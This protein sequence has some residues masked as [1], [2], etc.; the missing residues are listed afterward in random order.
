MGQGGWS[1]VHIA[2]LEQAKNAQSKLLRAVRSANVPGLGFGTVR[3][4]SGHRFFS[5]LAA[6]QSTVI[7]CLGSQ[8]APQPPHQ[9][10]PKGLLTRIQSPAEPQQPGGHQLM[11][12]SRG[13]E[14]GED[15]FCC[16][17]ASTW[18]QLLGTMSPG[19]WLLGW[20]GCV[21]CAKGSE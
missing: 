14:A 16:T 11:F 4:H 19:L 7:W 10:Q 12:F 9:T 5:S 8:T 3:I 21:S 6:A 2:S 18:W 13:L 17:P 1:L 15:R 20:E